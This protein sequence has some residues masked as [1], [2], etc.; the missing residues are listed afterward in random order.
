MP[1]QK[2]PPAPVSTRGRERVVAV[3]LLERGGEAV[4]EVAVDR[5]ADLRA[6]QGDDQEAVAALGEDRRRAAGVGHARTLCRADIGAPPCS[7]SPRTSGRSRSTPRSLI[8]AYLVGDVLVDAGH[9]A[10]GQAS[11]V[12]AVAGRGVKTHVL[13]HV[14]NDHAGGTKHVKET[15]GVPVW[16]GAGDA[17]ALRS[18]KVIPPPSVP[19]G[20]L[21]AGPAGS[22]KVEPD[23]ELR[24]G[25]E[26]GHGFTVLETPGHSPG[27]LSFWRESDRTLICGDVFFG[28]NV[29]TLQLRHPPAARDLHLRPAA[30]PPQ[31]APPGRARAQAA[32]VR[33]RAAAARPGRRQG[34]RRDAA[35]GPD[36]DRR[37]Q[38]NSVRSGSRSPRSTARSTSTQ[39][40]S[41]L[42]ASVRACGL[43][44]W[45]ASTPRQAPIA[46]SRRMNSR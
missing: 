17:Q 42:S 40:I 18:G 22:P 10:A 38:T 7:S 13:T 34:V 3:E 26:I 5:V 25:D 37:G 29:V 9:E 1:E 30:E 4:G 28:M 2:P 33:P 43:I 12:K 15:L 14:H 6:V 24:E 23:R 45:A 21:L 27:H 35:R 32:A 16:V 8:N 44:S 36:G 19:G 39:T 41:R 20:S 46:G 31:R 11:V